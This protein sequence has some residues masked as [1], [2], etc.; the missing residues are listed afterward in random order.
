M[1]NCSWIGGVDLN[2]PIINEDSRSETDTVTM[3]M[4]LKKK[5][6]VVRIGENPR[7]LKVRVDLVMRQK[8][9]N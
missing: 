5:I 2:E 8:L 7:P 4:S 6:Q 3:L 1:K 9:I